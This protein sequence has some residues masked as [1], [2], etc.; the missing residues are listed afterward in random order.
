MKTLLKSK[1]SV[2]RMTVVNLSGSGRKTQGRL[3][4][5]TTGTMTISV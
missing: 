3:S 1:L 2:K 4:Y 5:P